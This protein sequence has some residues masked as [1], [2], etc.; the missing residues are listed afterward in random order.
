MRPMDTNTTPLKRVMYNKKVSQAELSR[1]TS[2]SYPQLNTYVNGVNVPG[3]KIQK[4]IAEKLGVYVEEIFP[5]EQMEMESLLGGAWSI[6]ALCV[7]I[8]SPLCC[9]LTCIHFK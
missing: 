6:Q 5:H 4:L 1:A 2:I 7:L 3:E 8:M 9:F